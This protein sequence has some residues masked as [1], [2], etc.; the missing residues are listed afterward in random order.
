MSVTFERDNKIFK[1]F[2]ELHKEGFKLFLSADIA[3]YVPIF[4]YSSR[5]QKCMKKLRQN[6]EESISMLKD[7]VN[8]RRENFDPTVTRDIIDAYLQEEYAAQIEGKP[9]DMNYG[10]CSLIYSQTFF[11]MNVIKS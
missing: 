4:K 9:V 1:R 6:R 10:K 7:F 3:N 5:V 11:F 8:V 2:M